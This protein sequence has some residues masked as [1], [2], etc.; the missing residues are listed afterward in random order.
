MIEPDY[1]ANKRTELGFGRVDVLASVQTW[2]DREYPGLIRV[3]QLHQGVL[4][5][6]TSSSGVAGDLRLRQVELLA[7]AKLGETRLQISIGTIT[8]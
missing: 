7:V 4:R 1:F 5:L 6:V 2:C 8:D 3:K